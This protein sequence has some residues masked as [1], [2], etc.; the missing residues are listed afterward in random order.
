MKNVSTS[1][2]SDDDVT[3]DVEPMDDDKDQEEDSDVEDC[4]DCG[5]TTTNDAK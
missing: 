5:N 3:A 2:E 1:Y 4:Q